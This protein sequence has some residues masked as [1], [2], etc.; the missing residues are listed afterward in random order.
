MTHPK[1]QLQRSR[2]SGR[3][4]PT[5]LSILLL[6]GLPLT[7]SAKELKRL[8][9]PQQQSQPCA[10]SD[11]SE[12]CQLIRAVSAAQDEIDKLKADVKRAQEAINQQEKTIA[13]AKALVDAA[14]KEREASDKTIAASQKV[15]DQQ[16]K[17]IETYELAIRT[18]QQMVQMALTRID[19]LEKKIDKANGRAAALGVAL[20]V[21]GT[22]ATIFIHR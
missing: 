3:L 18:L 17:L 22:L 14:T 4:L 8:I 13:D 9:P 10:D 12:R 6:M 5:I 11:K 1:L 2:N 16:Q 20:T 7:A 19:T 21:I 15:I